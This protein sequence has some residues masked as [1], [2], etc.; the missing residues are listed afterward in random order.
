[1]D[2]AQRERWLRL[3]DVE[4]TVRDPRPPGMR[5]VWAPVF[6]RVGTRWFRSSERSLRK[7][8]EMLERAEPLYVTCLETGQMGLFDGETLVMEGE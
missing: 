5:P 2:Q 1:M 4:I 3:A 7:T 8:R 6:V